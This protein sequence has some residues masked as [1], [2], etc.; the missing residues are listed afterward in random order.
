MFNLINMIGFILTIPNLF[1]TIRIET[2]NDKVAFSEVV[3]E[4]PFKH[5]LLNN[6]LLM[7][8]TGAKV[9]REKDGRPVLLAVASTLLK[10]DS[11]KDRL[12]AEKVCRVK[13]IAAI[14]AQKKGIQVFHVETLK[15]QTKVL[16]D[17]NKESGESISELIQI[18]QTKVEG[19]SRDMPV[20]GY[21]RSKNGQVF[22][23][24]IG[25]IVNKNGE[26]IEAE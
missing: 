10:D 21:W 17:N 12:R 2:I 14:V 1:T 24:A 15:E 25:V 6:Q 26:V 11:P 18:T 8:V 19:I 7:E 13:A 9:I 3:I 16:N 4:K 20:V 22:Y 5:Y 23:I